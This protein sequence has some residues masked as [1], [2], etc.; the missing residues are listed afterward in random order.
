M[1]L[2]LYLDNIIAN[3][4]TPQ[5][6][7]NTIAESTSPSTQKPRHPAAESVSN[8]IHKALFNIGTDRA[9]I[10]TSRPINLTTYVAHKHKTMFKKLARS[11]ADTPIRGFR[12]YKLNLPGKFVMS[13]AL[14]RCME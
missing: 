14:F 3:F 2:H 10:K 5:L 12:F 7:E 9:F 13:V 11:D 1:Q 8:P 6:Y 4:S